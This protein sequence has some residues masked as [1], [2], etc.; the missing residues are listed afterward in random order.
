MGSDMP[1][2][3]RFIYEQTAMLSNLL[4]YL[5]QHSLFAVPEEAVATKA[6]EFLGFM[7]KQYG[8]PENWRELAHVE[9]LSLADVEP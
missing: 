9:F 5:A 3:D 7:A 4:P 1:L 6:D 8:W 2:P